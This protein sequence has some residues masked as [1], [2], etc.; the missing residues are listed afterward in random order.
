MGVN[1]ISMSFH[2]QPVNAVL[3][4]IR[5]EAEKGPDLI[6]LPETWN[7]LRPEPLDSETTRALQKIAQ[8]HG[9]YI[10]HPILRRVGDGRVFNTAVLIGRGGDVEGL[11]DKAYPYWDEYLQD[12]PITPGSEIP[13]FRTDFGVIGIAIC[14][15]A[16]FP[17]V[18][19]ALGRQGAQVVFWSSAYSGGTALCAHALQHHYAIITSTLW[20]DC[21]QIDITG[22]EV[23]Y[24]K[25]ENGILISHIDLDLNREIYHENFN[26]AA[27]TKLLR[28]HP[29][30]VAEEIAMPREQWFVLKGAPGTDLRALAAQYGLEPLRDYKRRSRRHIDALRGEGIPC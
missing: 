18:W 20:N 22:R 6:Q 17:C 30:C 14:F 26:M 27:K 12:P 10:I 1:I 15:D 7:G 21:M 8:E 5:G 2:D 3:A 28:E 4:A 19:E 9:V 16:N 11:Y 25:D 13:V 29:E 23:Y 24:A